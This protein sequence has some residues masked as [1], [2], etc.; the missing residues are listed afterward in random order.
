MTSV[1]DAKKGEKLVVI[2]LQDVDA[3]TILAGLK[4]S[5]F[6]NLWIPDLKSFH[7]IDTIPLLGSG[8]I[9]LGKIKQIAQEVFNI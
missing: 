4:Q 7:K 2:C 3:E 5:E 9:N 1:P 6:P 8:K